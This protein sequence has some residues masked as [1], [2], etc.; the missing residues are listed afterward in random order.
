MRKKSLFFLAAVCVVSMA[1][2]SPPDGD[3]T[4]TGVRF[5][6][7]SLE[8]VLARA[9]RESRPVMIDFFSDT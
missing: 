1:A 2:A 6:T 3:F 7:A 4:G 8:E 5:E 9:G